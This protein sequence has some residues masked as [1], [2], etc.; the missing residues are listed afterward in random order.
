MFE[1][2]SGDPF[3]SPIITRAAVSSSK[4]VFAEHT[5]AVASLR[6]SRTSETEFKTVGC[7]STTKSPR[8]KPQSQSSVAVERELENTVKRNR[9]SV[10]DLRMAFERAA[11]AKLSAKS[12]LSS[13]TQSKPTSLA[14]EASSEETH[15]PRPHQSNYKQSNIE[16]PKR[17]RNSDHRQAPATEPTDRRRTRAL[18]QAFE[19]GKKLKGSPARPL[20]QARTLSVKISTVKPAP[21]GSP[22]K[23]SKQKVVARLSDT[24]VGRRVLPGPPPSPFLQYWRTRR[25]TAPVKSGPSLPIMVSTTVAV[26]THRDSSSIVSSSRRSTPFPAKVEEALRKST[27]SSPQYGRLSQDGAGEAPTKDSPVKDRIGM[28]EHLSCPEATESSGSGSQKSRGS[29]SH[30]VLKSRSFVKRP[31]MS[32]LR[33]GARALRALSLTGRK[34]SKTRDVLVKTAGNSSLKLPARTRHSMAVVKQGM[35]KDDEVPLNLGTGSKPLGS[36]VMRTNTAARSDGLSLAARQESTFFVRGT[37]WKVPRMEKTVPPVK[38]VLSS[39]SSREIQPPPKPPSSTELVKQT[40]T[41][42]STLFHP[43]ISSSGRILPD[44]KSY[45]ALEQKRSWETS[46]T[47]GPVTVT[48]PFFDSASAHKTAEPVP[49]PGGDGHY[50]GSGSRHP[51][52]HQ[53]TPSVIKSVIHE[54]NSTVSLSPTAMH[55]SPGNITPG[56][57]TMELPHQTTITTVKKQYPSLYPSSFGKKAGGSWKNKA[58]GVAPVLSPDLVHAVKHGGSS[59]HGSL[60]WGRRA[61][62]AALGIGRRLKERRASSFSA[63]HSSQVEAGNLISP[64]KL[65]RSREGSAALG[66]QREEDEDWDVVVATPNCRLQHPRPSRVVDWRRWEEPE[67]AEGGALRSGSGSGVDVAP[68]SG[69]GDAKRVMSGQR[70]QGQEQ[71]KASWAKL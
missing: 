51:H 47:A 14:K 44:R 60:S 52:Y 5:K 41:T 28:F 65:L 20:L 48:D 54:T 21:N 45:G 63:K 46:T 2:R 69:D 32:E 3:T 13:P 34:E 37:M 31:S 56:A 62:A 12:S 67:P 24:S 19:H 15:Q 39:S 55:Y 64:R 16:T 23:E 42:K 50:F 66:Y 30:K 53:D 35:V 29:S 1:Q 70:G 57:S 18:A 68:N 59:R 38:P 27:S 25:E 61:A 11:P 8:S 10:A 4:P 7:S 40:A 33:R 43:S 49:V 6:A 58:G 22:T 9:H 26:R 17:P 36:R 71:R